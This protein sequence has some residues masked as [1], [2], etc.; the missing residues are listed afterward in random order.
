MAD[1]QRADLQREV[2]LWHR[3]FDW[4]CRAWSAAHHLAL[5]V[6]ALSSAGAAMLLKISYF[7]ATFGTSTVTDVSALLAAVGTLVTAVTA[8]VLP[9]GRC[10]FTWATPY[11]QGEKL[12]FAVPATVDMSSWNLVPPFHVE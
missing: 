9:D 4:G 3:R 1:D 10:C 2:N 5:L 7:K 11:G 8:F 6:A 12:P